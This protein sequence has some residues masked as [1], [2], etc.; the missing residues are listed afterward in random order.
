MAKVDQNTS[1]H[2]HLMTHLVLLPR[3]IWMITQTNN[4]IVENGGLNHFPANR[5]E[6]NMIKVTKRWTQ[7]GR[8]KT[9]LCVEAAHEGC[10]QLW[11]DRLEKVFM[12][13]AH[14]CLN[15]QQ[16]LCGRTPW[17]LFAR[18][19]APGQPAGPHRVVWGIGSISVTRWKP[20]CVYYVVVCLCCHL[21][22]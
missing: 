12:K 17:W 4:D 9:H 7:S 1:T 5:E 20:L 21:N 15:S 22:G 16:H 3:K 8:M 10:V 2:E 19:R 11:S 18:V 14:V 13:L 6:E